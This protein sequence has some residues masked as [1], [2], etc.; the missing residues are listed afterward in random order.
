M[1]TTRLRRHVRVLGRFSISPEDRL[2]AASRRALAYL[3]TKGP[4]VQRTL[5]SMELWP[6]MLETR[7]RANLRRAIWQLPSGWVSS[8][9]WD[10]RLEAETDYGE[11]RQVA[12]RALRGASLDAV[13]LDLLTHDLLPGWYDDWLHPE[14]DGFHLERIQSLEAA[15]RHSAAL[16]QYTLATRAGLAAVCA[17]P[18]RQSAVIALIE[19]HVAEGNRYEAVRRYQ[20]YCV[21]LRAELGLEPSAE[22]TALVSGMNSRTI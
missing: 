10:V 2:T 12:G 9:G 20:Q 6:A 3:A 7:S 4:V 13:E 21:L 14:Q 17:E 22:L 11:A 5:M 1:A 19:A 15:C 16:N 8:S 18:L